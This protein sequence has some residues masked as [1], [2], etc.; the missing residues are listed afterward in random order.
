[1]HQ[2]TA[3]RIIAKVSRAIAGLSNQYIRMPNEADEI[4]RVQNDFY[5]ICRFSRVI[6]Y[7]DGTHIKMQ[8]PGAQDGEAFRNSKLYFSI[9]SE[10]VAGPDLKIF[11]IITR[12]PGSTHDSTIFNAS[13]LRTRIEERQFQNAALLGEWLPAESLPNDTSTKSR[14]Y[15]YVQCSRNINWCLGMSVPSI[16]LW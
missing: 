11:D 4:I 9:N 5:R 12:W 8:S 7:I 14:Q 16:S 6:G 2:T 13:H 3:S 1:M 15:S 10:I